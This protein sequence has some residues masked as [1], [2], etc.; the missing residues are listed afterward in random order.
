MLKKYTVFFLSA[1]LLLTLA[2]FFASRQSAAVNSEMLDA[3][4]ML[5]DSDVVVTMDFDRTF[6]VAATSL[7][8]QDAKKIEHLKNLMKT[9]EN[10]LGVNPYQIRQIAAGFKLP[11][12]NSKDFLTDSEF[13]AIVRTT[14]SN[15]N[16][17]DDWSRKIDLITNF[18]DEQ[19]ASREFMDNFKSF[20]AFKF[21]KAA[22]EK[23]SAATQKFQDALKKTQD[24]SA[25][26]SALP[27]LAAS[28]ESVS[29]LKAKNQLVSDDLKEIISVLQ[30]DTEMQTLRETSIKLLNRW[31]AVTLD[32]AQRTA[33]LAAIT[34]ESKGIYPAFEKKH[35]N[36]K[37]LESL[38]AAMEPATGDGIAATADSSGDATSELDATLASLG[39]LPATKAAKTAELKVLAEGLDNLHGT[40]QS[41]LESLNFQTETLPEI[42]ETAP[43]VK[44]KPTSFYETLKKS[45]RR[46]TVNGKQMLVIDM[47][48]FDEP[49]AE[50][51]PDKEPAAKETIPNLAIGFLD[52]KTMVVGFEKTVAPFLKRDANYKNQ[53][54]LEMLGAAQN[55]LFVFVINSKATGQFFAQAA[56]MSANAAAPKVSE[57]SFYDNLTKD[58]NIYGSVNYDGDKATNDVSMS[59]GF[60]KEIVGNLSAPDNAK[61]DAETNSEADSTFE[62][63]GYQVGKD[64]FYDLFNSFKAVQAS[65]TFK[66]EKKKVAALVRSAPGIIE[67]IRTKN[68]K[69][70]AAQKNIADVSQSK[71]SKL[72][73]AADLLTA[74]QF[75]VDLAE[76]LTKNSKK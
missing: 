21:D 65:M 43:V 57:S 2:C 45:E 33:K 32:D 53:K 68:T 28:A 67:N 22:P 7:L 37:K 26:L 66:F 71:P 47:T 1:A 38:L 19:T 3:A 4:A 5:P 62:F 11:S 64:I 74:P 41:R 9:V 30:S 15:A 17:L 35:A 13:T 16:L 23:I 27:K 60:Y 49:N 36:A 48:K 52:D 29:A 44:P 70:S 34:K 59:V 54:V 25:K 39:K 69:N 42:A 10:Q 72:E 14:D 24:V 55:S 20:R 61:A 8:S 58:I 51:S 75:Y 50:K 76:L 46:E 73:S 6:N 56:K 40:L 31:N 18:K 63:A 12:D